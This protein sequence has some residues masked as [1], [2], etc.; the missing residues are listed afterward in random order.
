MKPLKLLPGL[1]HLPSKLVLLLLAVL[2]WYPGPLLQAQP[3]E[4]TQVVKLMGSRFEVTAVSPSDNLNR[5]AVQAGIAEIQRI[6]SLISSWDANSQTSAINSAAGTKAVPVDPELV[7]LILR[8]QKVSELTAGSFDISYAALDPIWKFDGSLTKIP[9]SQQV[10]ASIKL[11]NFRQV[12][13]DTLKG[14]VM[15]LQPN[16]KIGFG[17]IGKGY[18]ANRAKLVMQKLGVKNGLVNAG[19]DLIAWGHQTDGTPW[20]IGIVDPNDKD[21]IYA[22]LAIRNQSVVTSGD[23]ERFVEFNGVRYA[24]IID[25]RTGYPVRHTKSVTV[26]SPDAELSDALATAVFVM[27]PVKGLE[28][29]NKLKQIECLIVTADNQMLFSKNLKLEY[30]NRN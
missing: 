4:H 14:T 2:C 13:V 20:R 29:I 1:I 12:V 26:V 8:A 18:A 11:I 15:L 16:M 27:G 5:Q 17:A 7:G 25:P 24:H 10:K 28:L 9:D 6:E 19:G 21:K 23:Y 22:W 30:G 3:A